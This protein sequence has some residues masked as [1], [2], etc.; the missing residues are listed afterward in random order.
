MNNDAN[1]TFNCF[2]LVRAVFKPNGKYPHLL[3]PKFPKTFK[4]RNNFSLLIDHCIRWYILSPFDEDFF[5]KYR[6]EFQK[7]STIIGNAIEEHFRKSAYA[8]NCVEYVYKQTNS[9]HLAEE[10]LKEGELKEKILREYI[11]FMIDTCEL[12]ADGYSWI[13]DSRNLLELE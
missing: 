11:E 6:K 9:R 8:Q 12:L 5:R 4:V 13:K 1:A 7:G 3:V 10:H 2:Q